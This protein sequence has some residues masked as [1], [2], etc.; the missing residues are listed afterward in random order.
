[1]KC[2]TI[3]QP[4]A[5]LILRKGKDTENR[6]RRSH[7]RGRFLVHAGLTLDEEAFDW[8]T[9]GMDG[10]AIQKIRDDRGKILGSVEMVDCVQSSNSRWFQGPFG[11]VL[12]NPIIF[13]NPTPYKGKLNFF[14]VPE[15]IDT[16]R[17]T[18]GL[19]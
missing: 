11:Y 15:D 3:K 16:T 19:L 7:F 13:A 2:L 14:D 17:D 10:R 6:S 18:G 9:Q 1:M 4:W 8:F 5:H 12:K